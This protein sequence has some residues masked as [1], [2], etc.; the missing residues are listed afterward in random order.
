MTMK[1]LLV[2]LALS[3]PTSVGAEEV[4]AR[5]EADVRAL[6]EGVGERGLNRPDAR[7]RARVLVEDAWRDV[8]FAPHR[9]PF[10]VGGVSGANLEVVIPGRKSPEEIVVVGAH[11]DTV[12]GSPG[13]D[14]NASG[15]AVLLELS[16]RLAEA[17]LDRTLRLIAFDLEEPPAYRTPAMGSVVEAQACRTRADNVVFMLA[18]DGL[19]FY[20][21][22]PGSQTYPGPPTPDRPDTATFLALIGHVRS[23]DN[24]NR[25]AE[26]FAQHS[27]LPIET[28]A[29]VDAVPG[30]GWS[31]HWS[32]WQAGY[33]HAFFAT[34]TLPMRYAHYH[35]ATDTP[36]RL[37]YT[38]MAQ[39]VD[40]LEAVVRDAA[41]VRELDRP[42]READRMPFSPTP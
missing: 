8:G 23:P 34:D 42:R 17:R 4:S 39:A 14:D 31:D 7:E 6:A 29:G 32:F 9:L 37:D 20:D 22:A 3:L 16:R 33:D 36:D 18:L 25:A 40:G 21:E 30:V 26:V 19:G 13:A 2:A 10:T 28:L 5:L 1:N 41:T 27:A 15:V 24:L 35:E 11:Y 38:R 12:A